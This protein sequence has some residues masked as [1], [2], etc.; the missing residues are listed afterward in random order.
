MNIRSLG[1]RTDLALLRLGGSQ[2][3]DRG[4]HLVVRTPSNPSHWWGNFILLSEVPGDDQA[5]EWLQRFAAEFPD[6]RHVAL[7][8]DAVDRKVEDLAAFASLG[9]RVETQTVMTA[10]QVHKPHSWN[11]DAQ[12]RPLTSDE[13]WRQSVDLRVLCRDPELEPTSYRTFAT[14]KVK[15]NR[16]LVEDGHGRWYGALLDGRLVS[17]MG[18]FRAG[19]GLARFQ[20]VETDPDYRRQGL[21]GSLVYETSRFGLDEL[22]ARTLVMCADPEYFAI[23]LYR[24][25]GFADTQTQL[26]AERPP[27]QVPAS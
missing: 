13:D 9:L 6:S 18:L 11:R 25:V 19:T 27:A 7:G 15:S 8:F 4:D 12:Y 22:H 3:D 20:S 10:G 1:F 23:D 21:A 26:Q 17:Q 2:V 16:Q 14:A 5:G 24:S